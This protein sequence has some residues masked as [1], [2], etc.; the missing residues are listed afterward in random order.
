MASPQ[1]FTPNPKM[2]TGDGTE[3]FMSYGMF[4]DIMRILGA[5]EDAVDLLIS[6]SNVRDLVVRRLFTKL[7]HALENTEELINPHDMPVS[8]LELDDIVAWVADHVIH[9]TISTAEKTRPVVERYQSRQEA[10]LN[11]SKSG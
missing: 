6:D 11:Q 4:N 2:T 1:K 7:D 8:P 10:F 5:T 3:L 9:F